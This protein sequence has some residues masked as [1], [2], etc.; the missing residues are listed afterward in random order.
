M[1]GC[2][3]EN[4]R[5]AHCLKRRVKVP[6]PGCWQESPFPIRRARPDTAY[7]WKMGKVRIETVSACPRVTFIMR[8]SIPCQFSF[9]VLL[10]RQHTH[11]L[12]RTTYSQDWT[13]NF[14]TIA[15]HPSTKTIYEETIQFKI[16]IFFFLR[17]GM[18]HFL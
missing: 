2:K 11:S 8:L 18:S 4:C 7:L 14:Q 13:F 12:L 9:S 15:S 5:G 1:Q 3:W 10:R 17:R 6:Q 16:I